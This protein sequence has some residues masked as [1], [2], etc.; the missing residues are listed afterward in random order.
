MCCA[1]KGGG[2]GQ[3]VENSVPTEV[4]KDQCQER[5]LPE[6]V[7]FAERM[8]QPATKAD[9][10]FYLAQHYN[11]RGKF[12][13]EASTTFATI[14]RRWPLSGRP[15]SI[16]DER[17]KPCEDYQGCRHMHTWWNC[18]RNLVCVLSLYVTQVYRCWFR[19]C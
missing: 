2:G 4:A 19:Y 12:C 15:V 1:A 14:R 8:A 6:R 3:A 9:H 16:N 18:R 7:R 5:R 11:C 17:L 13:T 10:I